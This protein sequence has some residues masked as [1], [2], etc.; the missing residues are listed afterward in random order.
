LVQPPES[1]EGLGAVPQYIIAAEGAARRGRRL[2]VGDGLAIVAAQLDFVARH[3]PARVR[4]AP[5]SA[6]SRCRCAAS[7]W[8][9]SV[10]D[11]ETEVPLE[12]LAEIRRQC[13]AADDTSEARLVAAGQA[14]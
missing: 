14:G 13:L 11:V 9:R 10:D 4:S 8:S 1:L 12:A 6:G 5:A 2:T 3:R 7:R